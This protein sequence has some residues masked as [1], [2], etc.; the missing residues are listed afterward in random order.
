[1]RGSESERGSD[2]GESESGSDEVRVLGVM[3]VRVMGV[4]E[5]ES[6]SGSYESDECK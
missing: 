1:M 3:R 2:E 5:S 4:S 6:E